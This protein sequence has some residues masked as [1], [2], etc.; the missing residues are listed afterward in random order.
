MLK[1]LLVFLLSG[2]QNEDKIAQTNSSCDVK[3]P[4]R[5]CVFT[6]G[7]PSFPHIS[8]YFPFWREK[9]ACHGNPSYSPNLGPGRHAVYAQVDT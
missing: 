9:G 6:V 3:A 2:M 8:P 5:K 7:S 4:F 1:I